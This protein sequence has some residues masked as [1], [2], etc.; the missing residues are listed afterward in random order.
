MTES[1]VPVVVQL[2]RRQPS[3]PGLDPEV[4]QV[5]RSR[6]GWTPRRRQAL[7]MGDKNGQDN[8]RT[9]VLVVYVVLLFSSSSSR[10]VF[11]PIS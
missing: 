6:S 11:Y 3:M 5:I 10:M 7:D 9:Y 4:S 1:V 2:I 8:A